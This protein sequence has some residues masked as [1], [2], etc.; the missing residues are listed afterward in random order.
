MLEGSGYLDHP[1]FQT[2]GHYESEARLADFDHD[3]VAAGVIFHG[4]TN[5]EP[6][7]FVPQSF[8]EPAAKPDPEMVVVGQKI[9]NRWLV[10][11][12][13]RSPQR[14]V[15]LAYLPFSDIE[16]AVREL[17]WAGGEHGLRGV[18]FPAMRDGSYPSTTAAAGS[19][20]GQRVKS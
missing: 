15:G 18:N 4:S 20:S 2:R 10:D 14:H 11:F 6:I 7:P 8:G 3:G 9:Y 12:V 5:M 13:A 1:N 19:R 17:Y 16:S